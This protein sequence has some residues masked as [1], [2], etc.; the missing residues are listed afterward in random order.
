VPGCE[1]NCSIILLTINTM[2]YK[3]SYYIVF[4]DEFE[5]DAEGLTRKRIA[6]STRSAKALVLS[7]EVCHQ[8]MDERWDELSSD[9]FDKLRTLK[10]IVPGDEHELATIID[11]NNEASEKESLLYYVIQNTANCQLGCDYCGQVHSKHNISPD[12][13]EKILDRINSRIIPGQHKSLRIGWFGGEPLLGLKQIREMT[14]L[15]RRLAEGN[16]LTYSAKVVTNG[17][18][19]KEGIFE[20]LATQLGIDQVEVTLDGTAEFHDHRRHTKEKE[21]TFDII[22]RNLKAIIDRPDF[23]DLKCQ[24]T[25]RCNVDERNMGGVSPLIQLLAENGFPEKIG[26]FYPVGVYSWGN[27]AHKKSLTKEE[28][29]EKEIDWMMEMYEA[30]FKFSLLPG[31]VKAVCLAVSPSSE[32]IDAFGNLYNCTE[33]PYVDV[34]KGSQHEMGNLRFPAETYAKVKPLN[35]WND[36]ILNEE[37]PCATCKMLPVCGGGCPKS[38]NEQMRACP[39]NKFN[40]REKLIL[41][42]LSTRE[43]FSDSLHELHTAPTFV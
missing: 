4:T 39:S 15:L 3:L 6:F 16:Q 41:S 29:A 38:W 1:L 36:Q 27:D 24:L 8:L 14:P 17:L 34:Y 20:E 22:F 9:V 35:N 13:Y 19:L 23:F 11:E 25:L 12:L 42:Y 37:F 5:T 40:I 31:R 33:V 26:Y 10:F 18:S 21:S 28:F 7:A 32:V 30:G 2:T 43:G